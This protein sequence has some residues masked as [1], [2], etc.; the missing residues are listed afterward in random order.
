MNMKRVCSVIALVIVLLMVLSLLSGI[1]LSGVDASAADSVS[2]MQKELNDIAK[3]KEELENELNII[4]EK[5]EEEL[6]KKSLIDEQINATRSEIN[7]LD[8]MISTLESQLEEAEAELEEA[9][10]QIEENLEL[11]KNRIRSAYEQGDASMLEILA[12]SKSIY[13]LITKVEIVGEITKKDNEVIDSIRKNKEIIEQKREE[14]KDNKAANEQ[15]ASQLSS[16]KKQL[17]KKQEASEELIDEMNGSEAATR[18][19]VLAAEA[20]EEQLQSEIRAALAAASSGS[21]SGVVDSG[22]FMWPLDSKYR[23]I[24]SQFG[25]RTHPIT[26]VYKLHTGVDIS[27]SGIRGASIYAAKGGTVM[28]AG[29][30]TGYGNYV[31]I[32]HGDGYATLYG[33]A[34]T[35]LV[36]AGQVV[37]K[38]DVLGYVGSSGYSTGPHLHFEIMKNGEYTNPLGYFSGVMSF[39]YS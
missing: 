10:A 12:Q 27:S 11:S 26:H 9:E 13:D 14:I 38:G 1:I 5:K 6:Q 3:K 24:T 29:Y 16:K 33:H 35:L 37:N 22:D 2:S 25:Y 31:L 4:S 18:R 23:N 36:S 17:E 15:A 20:A 28:K 8:E 19:A 34:D 21:S 7:L 39:T 30:N 32:N